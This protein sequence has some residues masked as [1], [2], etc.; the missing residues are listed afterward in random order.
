MR[1]A[2]STPT[3]Q[4]APRSTPETRKWIREPTVSP[5]VMAA[6]EPEE[7]R[8]RTSKQSEKWVDVLARKDLRKKKPK[9]APS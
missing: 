3:P 5:E 7:K 2:K 6:K 1:A 4:L 9:P 8:P